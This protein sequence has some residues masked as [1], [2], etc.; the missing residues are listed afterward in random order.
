[1]KKLLSTLLTALMLT[2]LTAGAFAAD[3][4]TPEV[5]NLDVGEMQVYDFGDVKLHAYKTNDPIDDESFL[6]ET[7]DAIIGI[8]TPAFV[9]NLAEYTQYIA[10]L[11]KPMNTIM[12]PYHPAGGDAYEGVEILGTEEARAAQAEGGSN[13]ALVDGF[14][15]AFGEDFN[16][17]IVEITNLVEPG[18]ITVDGLEFVLTA[19]L[20]GFDIEIPAINAVFTHMF[21]ADVH[22]ILVSEDQI[23]AMIA[24]VKGYQ[25]KGYALVLSSH[26]TPENQDAV[27]TKLAYLERA[28]ELA[29]SSDSAEA[30]TAAMN[31]AFPN[32]SGANYLDISAGALFQ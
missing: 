20:D 21:G 17:S 26:Y 27:A 9:S 23:D 31:E 25:E 11:G 7:A 14:I 3:A 13:R 18:T 29:Q 22:N 24:Q 8:E 12:M 6:I 5:K 2:T 28:K 16:G 30:F 19:T 15:E 1:M 10:D 32:Y 4:P